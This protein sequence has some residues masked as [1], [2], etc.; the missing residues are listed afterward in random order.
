[1]RLANVAPLMSYEFMER[2]R[3]VTPVEVVIGG[4][5]LLFASLEFSRRFRQLSFAP[6]YLPIGGLLSGFLGGLSGMQGALRSAFLVRA[7]LTKEAFI[8]TGVAIAALI[9]ISRL[10]VYSTALLQEARELDYL[11]LGAAVVSAFAGT[12]LG[13]RYL[14]KVTMAQMQRF[15][16]VLLFA[17]GL[18]LII[19]LV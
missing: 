11:L 16:A 9:D 8:G 12:A 13:N 7:G 17:V 4:L 10:G 18:G 1:M 5:L 6:K 2:S 19:G 15:V 14:K 3:V